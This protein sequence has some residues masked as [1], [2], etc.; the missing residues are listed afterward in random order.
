M[1]RKVHLPKHSPSTVNLL[2]D[3]QAKLQAGKGAGYERWAK[4]FNLKQMAQT[5]NFLQEHN[6]LEYDALAVK[7]DELRS[8][9]D[10]LSSDI[11]GAEK[12][13][14]EISILQTHIINYSKTRDVYVAYRNAGYSKKFLAEH[15]GDIV[16]HKAAK[17]AFDD[18]GLKKLPTIKA[19]RGEYA[20]LLAGKKTTYNEYRRVRDERR[21][22][23]TAKANI[24]RLLGKNMPEQKQEKGREKH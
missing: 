17:K 9:F 3:I 12:R 6:L 10:A 13:M 18:K 7:V 24:D 11:K 4:V 20:E 14:A 2:V 21:E 1:P 19:L 22:A 23:L 16:L 8:Q 15:E 5:L